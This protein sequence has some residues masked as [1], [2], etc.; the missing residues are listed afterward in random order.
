LVLAAV[1]ILIFG[2]I[3]E[4]KYCKFQLP[5][6]TNI[7]L[8]HND[9]IDEHFALRRPTDG[10]H[11]IPIQLHRQDSSKFSKAGPGEKRTSAWEYRLLR[12]WRK[13]QPVGLTKDQ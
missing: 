3:F 2:N 6:I 7:S 8:C 11:H 4:F 5:T 9:V 12:T 10:T 1:K 13:Y